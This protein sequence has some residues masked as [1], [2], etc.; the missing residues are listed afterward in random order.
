LFRKGSRAIVAF[1]TQQQ[2]Q[3]KKVAAAAGHYL[4]GEIGFI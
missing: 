1:A 2:Q 4:L 3:Q